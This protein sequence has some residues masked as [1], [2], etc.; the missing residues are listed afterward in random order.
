MK[1]IF[2]LFILMA[3]LMISLFAD[4]QAAIKE[5][6]GIDANSHSVTGQ[7]TARDIPEGGLLLIP[8]SGSDRVMA[9]DPVTGDLYDADFIPLDDVNLSTP[10][11]AALHPDGNSILVSDQLE[12]GLLQYDLEGNFLG[13][14]AP[15]GGVNNAILDNV[16][17][18]GL[19]ADGNILVTTASGSNSDAIVEFD[20]A[21]N[22]IGNFIAPNAAIMDGPFCVVYRDVQDDY[23]VT[24]STS[25]NVHQYD[26]TGAYIG[27]LVTGL[28]FLEQVS[29]TPSGNLLIAAFSAPSGCYEYTSDGTYVGYYDLFTGL[30]GVHELGNGNILVTNGTGVY[31]IDRNNTLI[32]TK[33]DGVNARFIH[34]ADGGGGGGGDIVFEDDFE[35]GLTQWVLEADPAAN[36]TWD[37]VTTQYNSPTHSLTESPAGNYAADVTYTASLATPLDFS[38]AMQAELNFWMKYDIEGGLFDFLYIDVSPDNGTTWVNIGTYYGEGNDWAEYNISLGGFVGNS[39]VL[40]RWQIVTDGGYEVNG[41]YLDDVVVSTSNVDNTPPLILYDGP[42]FYEGTDVDFDFEAELIDISGIATADVVYTVE[43][44]NE[45]TLPSTGN[46]G[47]TYYFTIPFTDYGDQI[48]FKIVAVDAAPAAN[49]GESVINSY[50]NGHH[51]IYDTGWVDFY[52]AFNAGTGAAV[53]MTNPAG[54]DLNLDFALIRNYIDSNLANADMEFHVWGD[55][56]GVPGNDLITP[57]MVTPEAT[58]ENN[59]PMTRIDLRAYAAELDNIQGDFYIG[60]LVPVDIV[61]CTETTTG[62]IFG[63]SYTWNGTAWT[64]DAADFHFR[65]VVELVQGLVPGTIEGNVTDMDTGNPIEGA[66]VTAGAYSTTTDASGDYSMDVDP[67]TYTVA[68]NL[69]GYET[70]EQTDVVVNSS[71]VVVVDFAMQHSYNPP[72]NL[73]YQ[74]SS[75]NVILQ[76]QEPVG[77]GLTEYKVYRDGTEI[78]NISAMLYIDPSV[79]SGVY[80]YHVTAMYG[81]Y[82]SVPS[83][84]VEV[85]VTGTDPGSMPLVNK[86]NGNYPNPFNPS[87]IINYSVGDQGHVFIEVFNIKGEKVTILRDGVMEPGNY[88]VTWDGRDINGNSVSSGVYFYKMK[89]GKFV[90]TKKMILMK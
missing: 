49:E 50:I 55:N 57:F 26:N 12:D 54:M 13:W 35:N 86:L 63:H 44:G 5:E 32:S 10:I 20:A 66:V 43:G 27:D 64:L 39:Q 68:G 16:R 76:W 77:P 31:E 6:M 37:L 87:T 61:H 8:D 53:K 33:I 36:N 85:T 30:R 38:A 1:K 45:I 21:G 79:P 75:P 78:A 7:R 23:L 29:I 56:G 67:A 71:D 34:F 42:E 48:D 88:S 14:F 19:K 17:G 81:T 18:W 25:D 52:I 83:N 80:T 28:N 69:G 41:M 89:A 2:V 59:S 24:A 47:D 4:D 3:L 72:V 82:E 58:L 65:S 62:T 22:H 46:T 84:E 90:S 11:E 51:L 73:T 40:I 74:F 9:F 60:F 70:Y 15:A